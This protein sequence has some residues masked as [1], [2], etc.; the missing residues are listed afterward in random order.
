LEPYRLTVAALMAIWLASM[1]VDLRIRIRKSLFDWPLF[2]IV[3]ALL[4]SVVA[5][6]SRIDTLAVDDVVAKK[7]TF[8]ASYLIVYYL[9]VSVVRDRGM[10][11]SLLKVLV[12]GGAI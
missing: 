7:L 1:L 6:S 9:I 8:F 2:V 10:A 5:N 11:E 3:I 4:G 12:A